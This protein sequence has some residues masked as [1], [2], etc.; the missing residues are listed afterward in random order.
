MMD[1]YNMVCSRFLIF[2]FTVLFVQFPI[3]CQTNIDS[4][5]DSPTL[6]AQEKN[7]TS[8]GEKIDTVGK[9]P[10]IDG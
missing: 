3:V 4:C 2:R 7:P 6:H 9:I 10:V 5:G 1:G 8:V